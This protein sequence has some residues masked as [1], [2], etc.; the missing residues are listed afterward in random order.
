MNKTESYIFDIDYLSLKTISYSF[1]ESDEIAIR[2]HPLW[3]LLSEE[4]DYADIFLVI[5]QTVKI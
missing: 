2:E 5:Y 4:E 3:Y 1:T